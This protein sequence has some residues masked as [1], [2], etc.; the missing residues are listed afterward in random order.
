MRAL[1]VVVVF[2]LFI[3]GGALC[4]YADAAIAGT[5]QP[6]IPEVADKRRPEARQQ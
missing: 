6:P 5:L 4:L 2:W 3:L 1:T